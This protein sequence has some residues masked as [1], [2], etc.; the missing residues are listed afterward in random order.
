[1]TNLREHLTDP[2]YARCE[3]QLDNYKRNSQTNMIDDIVVENVIVIGWRQEGDLDVMVV[4]LQTQ[5]TDYVVNDSTGEVVRGSKDARKRMCY[6]WSLVRKTGAKSGENLAEI[7]CP[8]CGATTVMNAASK[9]EYCGSLIENEIR[10][11]AISEIKGLSQ[12]T[13]F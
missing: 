1:M 2:M 6:E 11:W 7:V 10:V 8:N 9:C 13:L 12:Q 4:E 5:I 3:Q